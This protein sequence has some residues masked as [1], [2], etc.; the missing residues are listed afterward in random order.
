[1]T[2]FLCHNSVD[3]IFSGIYDAWASRLGHQNVQLQLENTNYELFAEYR[4]VPIDAEKAAK[5]ARTLRLR[6][7]EEDYTHI[8]QA[9]LSKNLNKAN[10]IYRTV[11]Q[12]LAS[13]SQGFIMQKLQDRDICRVFEM[14][15]NIGNEAHHYLG[16]VRFRELKKRVMFSEICPDNQVLP[17]IGEHFADRF[18]TEHFL[19]YDKRHQ[20]FIAHEAYKQW[21]LVAGESLNREMVDAWSEEEQGF[22]DLWK[23]F[24]KTI[25]IEERRN[26]RLQKQFLPL[27]FRRFLTEEF[28]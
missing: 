19:I 8:Y 17:L 28:Q 16:F 13:G 20:V 6:M 12:G 2:I 26:T 24:C 25:G 21:V 10:C 7:G 23:G 9:A 14:S 15:R 4:E 1:M 3:G 27:K 18:P 11:V 5:V 22:Q